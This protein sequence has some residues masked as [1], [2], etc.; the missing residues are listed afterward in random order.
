MNT[1]RTDGEAF[2]EAGEESGV[3]P[4]APS[5]HGSEAADR[6]VA[7]SRGEEAVESARRRRWSREFLDQ[8]VTVC[9]TLHASLG[10]QVVL[11]MLS[12]ERRV[13][14]LAMMGEDYAQVRTPASINWIR[15]GCVIGVET[16]SA[17]SADPNAFE[18]GEGCLEDVLDDLVADELPVTLHLTGG[19]RV[20]G[21]VLSVGAA[22]RVEVTHS[23][24]V[25]VI[26]TK[27]IEIIVLPMRPPQ[28]SL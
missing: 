1:P 12:G 10:E 21:L 16:D 7:D 15:L 2:D 8:S 13:A 18:P 11:I 5:H 4:Q 28:R 17:V 24:Q 25:A 27:H 14:Q 23:A 9:S 20:T 22:V 3:N 6:Y 19:S 26:D